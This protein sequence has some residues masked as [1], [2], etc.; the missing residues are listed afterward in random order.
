MLHSGP[1]TRL[2]AMSLLALHATIVQ[3]GAAAAG[4]APA[5]RN[6]P[7]YLGDDARSHFS[8]L[9]EIRPEN[10]TRLK[11]AWTF[12]CGD[13][14]ADNRSQ[15]QCNPLVINGVLYGT[16]PGL[17][18]IALDAAT[19]QL[20]WRF[21]PASFGERG[22]VGV[23][24][25]VV[26]WENK[27]DR[28]ILY[29]AGAWLYA[30][31]AVTGKPVATFA[32]K[33]RFDVHTGLGRDTKGLHIDVSTPGA[34]FGNLLILGSRVGEGPGPT[35][36]GHIRAIDIPTGKIAWV[37]HTIPYPGEFGYDTWPP[38]AWKHIGA[39]N[40]WTGIAVDHKRG[41]V[42]IPTGSPAFDFWGG[43]RLGAGLFGNCLLALDATTGT[44]RWHFQV[45]HHDIWDRDLPAPPNLL[46]VTRNGRKI[47]AVAQVTKSGHVFVF[48][49]DT[50]EPLFP[51]VETPVPPSDLQGEATSPTQPI[52]LKPEPFSRQWFTENDATGISPEA[53]AFVLDKLRKIR[54]HQPFLPPSKEGTIIFPGFDG[55]AEW[56]GAGV[57]PRRGILYVNGNEMPWIQ[58][59][60]ESKRGAG[61]ALSSGE[62][63]YN[64]IC[65]VCH[66]INR[67]G[68]PQR[69]SPPLIDIEKKF[70][71]EDV[72]SLISLGKGNMPSFAFLNDAQMQSTVAFLF[73][74]AVPA[75]P[76]TTRTGTAEEGN[77]LGMVPY[78]HTGYNRFFDQNG[79]PAVKPP[80]GTLNAIDL[81]TG[82]YLWR[83]PL[84]EFPELTRRG[85]PPTGTENYGGPL[86][87]T[88]GLIFIA[89]S[90]DEKFRAFDRKLGQTLWETTLP[91]G[92]Y[93]TPCTYEAGGRQFVVIA[94]GGGKMGTKSGDAY[95]A[96][97][98]PGRAKP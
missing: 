68:D 29:T 95:V 98:L 59:M 3:L 32:D 34:V 2:V 56:G 4:A 33:G 61:G 1:A 5:G 38:E 36:P 6:W 84:G 50:G 96:F 42:L 97:A 53:K 94:C 16:T 55:G 67:Q 47:D 64:Q 62:Q 74:D 77:A 28:R 51:V 20:K 58:T 11:V 23:N 71:R 30:I 41:L 82:D 87:T 45:V 25:G 7:V 37:F 65:A 27:A 60:V 49:R 22:S 75:E 76:A 70:K 73:G 78:S 48:N 9:T 89:A 72:R 24:R 8:T 46:T 14:R 39:A 17:K 81:N 12:N 80:W 18:L 10:V 69:P 92:G 44:R 79:Y 19:G 40:C 13:G 15:I 52:P 91:A 93:A 43:N 26:Y 21:D 83:V 63:I 66:G 54:P 88:S 57:D 90:K 31:D 86:V 35:A 85:I